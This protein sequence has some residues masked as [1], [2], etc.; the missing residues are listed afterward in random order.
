MA[1]VSIVEQA[2]EQPSPN[3]QWER[4]FP[5]T[6][7]EA[8]TRFLETRQAYKNLDMPNGNFADTPVS[9][10]TDL[11]RKRAELNEEMHRD[12]P[13]YWSY[14]TI[15]QGFEDWATQKMDL[16][17]KY[18]KAAT[19]KKIY[20]ERRMTSDEKV[21]FGKQESQTEKQE[22]E[23]DMK[24]AVNVMHGLFS[25]DIVDGKPLLKTTGYSDLTADA[26]RK[27]GEE[28]KKW[29]SEHKDLLKRFPKLEGIFETWSA[30]KNFLKDPDLLENF[31]LVYW[32]SHYQRKL[33]SNTNKKEEQIL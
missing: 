18:W 12:V 10:L 20:L 15:P 31:L 1:D 8:Q 6:Y 28:H 17:S 9:S 13:Q 14:I 25:V 23:K 7:D 4:D 27:V 22:L 21:R 32:F 5:K 16:A 11:L 29:T 24:E 30:F 33:N 19:M 3:E 26:I 2:A